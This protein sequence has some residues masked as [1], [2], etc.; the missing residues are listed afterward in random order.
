M[1][2]TPVIASILISIILICFAVWFRFSP[3]KTG[4]AE[5]VAVTPS[6]TEPNYEEVFLNP[7]ATSTALT[8]TDLFSRQLFTDY[9]ALYSLNQT[10]SDNLE[11]LAEKYADGI[12]SLETSVEKVSHDKII[13][14]AESPENL[15]SYVSQ[16]L[17]LR[18][19]YAAKIR[20]QTENKSISNNLDDPILKTLLS[21]AQKL[22]LSAA[23]EMLKVKV[24]PSLA[25]NHLAIINNYLSNA[26]A[27]KMINETDSDPIKVYS[28]IQLHVQSSS[29]EDELFMQMQIALAT[30]GIIIPPQEYR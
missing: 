7:P 11:S 12:L 14:A 30:N 21:S 27:L 6:S 29:R 3:Q 17:A 15:R 4:Y 26:K 1:N 22:Y 10:S 23:E 5:L 18:D 16:M 20:S 13:L 8:V 19:N 28:A 25:T 24:P 9:A 2:R